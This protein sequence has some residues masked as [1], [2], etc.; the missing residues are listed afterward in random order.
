MVCKEWSLTRSALFTVRH[1][2]PAGQHD[3]GRISNLRLSEEESQPDGT[4]CAR[5]EKEG[6]GSNELFCTTPF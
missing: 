3:R 5:Q 1:N 4:V 6:Y 2:T